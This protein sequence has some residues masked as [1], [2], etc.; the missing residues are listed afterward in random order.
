[1]S[2]RNLPKLD[3]VPGVKNLSPLPD[4]AALAKWH[5]DIHAATEGDGAVISI[6]DTIGADPFGDGVTS[7]R[8]AGALRGIG[9]NPV[10]VNINSPGGDFFEGVAIYTLL[11]E[12]PAE[13][14][15]KVV[16]LAASAASVIAMAGDNL[17]VSKVGFIMVHNA[18]VLAMGNRTDLRAAA[19]F[20]EPFDQAM[21]GL[22]ADRAGV[23]PSVAAAWMDAETWFSGQEA[24]DVGLANSVLGDTAIEQVSSEATRDILAERSAEM[25]FRKGGMSAREAKSLVA[26][27]KASS[28]DAKDGAAMRDAGDGELVTDLRSLLSTFKS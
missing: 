24:V 9:K 13:V 28:R 25:A 19:D 14:T 20:L 15:V 4:E 11:A 26:Q 8:I 7:K 6:Y 17:M 2:L 16:G 5:P 10:T 3:P 1:M 22:Y 12:H 21:A 23:E 27:L 18:W